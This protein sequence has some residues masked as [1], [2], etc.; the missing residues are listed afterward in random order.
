VVREHSD[1]LSWSPA[2]LS[3]AQD[4]KA[5]DDTSYLNLWFLSTAY[6]G[7]NDHGEDQ[8]QKY[9]ALRRAALIHLQ[10]L[11][12]IHD[13]IKNSRTQDDLKLI[14]YA[15]DVLRCTSSKTNPWIICHLCAEFATWLLTPLVYPFTFPLTS[16]LTFPAHILNCVYS[17]YWPAT[18]STCTWCRLRTFWFYLAHRSQ[19]SLEISIRR[20]SNDVRTLR[21]HESD[22]A[23]FS[24]T[25]QHHLLTATT[26]E[27]GKR[28]VV[29]SKRWKDISRK[30][31]PG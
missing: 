25:R 15:Q 16:P 6:N 14:E 31:I 28:R 18:R 5:L 17:Y 4:A 9:K 12:D 23:E 24:S 30:V 29:I 13:N 20:S 27:D 22:R 2:V 19:K 3:I 21:G 11:K 1:W 10:Q 7:W 8:A 26:H